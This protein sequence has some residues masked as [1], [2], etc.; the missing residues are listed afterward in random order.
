MANVKIA[1]VTEVIT[2]VEALL[3]RAMGLTENVKTT[4]FTNAQ[5]WYQ[6]QIDETENYLSKFE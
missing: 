2:D 5:E 4:G 6:V 3:I 1:N